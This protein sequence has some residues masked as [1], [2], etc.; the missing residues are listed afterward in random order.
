MCLSFGLEKGEGQMEN[1]FKHPVFHVLVI[2]TCAF[3]YV[4]DSFMFKTRQMRHVQ[5]VLR[6]LHKENQLF[7]KAGK[8]G[9]YASSVNFLHYQAPQLLLC[10]IVLIV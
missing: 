9:I 6:K 2:Y 5:I 1:C 8:C 7:V 10:L 3:V 4:D